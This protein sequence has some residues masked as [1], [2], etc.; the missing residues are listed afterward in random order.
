LIF[1]LLACKGDP[2]E[3]PPTESGTPTESGLSDSGEAERY[4][5]IAV[6][7]T[8]D[9]ESTAGVSIAQGGREERWTTDSAGQVTIT[10]DAWMEGGLVIM[11]SHPEAR[12]QGNEPADGAITIELT[13][14]ADVDNADFTFQDPGTPERNDNT[15]MCAHC[16]ITINAD[17]VETPHAEAA[18][19]VPLHDLYAGAAGALADETTCTDAGGQWWTGIGPGTAAAADRCY[20][21]D[22]VLPLL[23]ADC[24]ETSA[25]DSVATEVGDCA[26]CHAPGID[27]EVGGRGLL[28]AT[29]LS[30]D[31]GV[32]CD[33]CHKVE[34]V[35]LSQPAGVAGRL[36]ILRPSEESP[37]AGLGVWLPLTFGP[38]EDVLNPRMGSVARDHYKSADFCAGCHQHDQAVLVPGVTID[39]DRWPDGVLPVHSTYTEWSDGPFADNAPCQ[40]CHMPPDPDAGN[41]SDIDQMADS[42]VGIA[43]GWWRPPGQVRRHTWTGPRSDVADMLGLAA[44]LTI[45]AAVTDDTLSADVTVRNIGPGHAL[46]TGEPMRSMVLLVEATCEGEP[47]APTGGSV[48]PDFGGYADMQTADGDW[49]VWPGAEVGQRVQ[50][51]RQTSDFLDYTGPGRFGDGS[52]TPEQRGMPVEEAVGGATITATDGDTVTFDTP[53]P[54]GDLAYRI[55]HTAT[56]TTGDAIASRAGLPGFGFARVMVG[57]DGARMVPHF[58]AVDV[59]SDNRLPPQSSWTSQHTFAADCAT[60]TVTAALLYRS[61]PLDLAAQRGWEMTERVMTTAEAQP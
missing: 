51:V 40:S 20:L 53:L 1:L 25:C 7:V 23:N 47:L 41:S 36:R 59:A 28:E 52:F 34:S 18:S 21:G 32:H 29:G 10:A 26:D 48:V 45:A 46:P 44:T 55:T 49:S 9:G 35:D 12:I 31:Y 42:V 57:E 17:W 8:L 27:G 14:F 13:R 61:Y 11:A 15:S 19:G 2:S 5:D 39:T 50:V 43:G 24:G 38:Y 4:Q 22:G 56:P 3:S 33:V 60:P 58:A 16:H 6:T 54:A 37:S 30:Y